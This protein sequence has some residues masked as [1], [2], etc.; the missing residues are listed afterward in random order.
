[1]GRLI[2]LLC[3]SSAY[4]PQ[5]RELLSLAGNACLDALIH[6]LLLR[7]RTPEQEKKML[8][9]GTESIRFLWLTSIGNRLFLHQHHE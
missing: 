4:A 1:M 5:R 7:W 8:K 6:A 2:I 9:C 3:S